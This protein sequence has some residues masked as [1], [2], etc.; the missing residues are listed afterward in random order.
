MAAH[1]L[2]T[3]DIRVVPVER[4]GDVTYHGPGQLVAYPIM[5]LPHAKAVRPFV[6]AL[7]RAVV[8]VA[9]SY[10]VA[11][12]P[13]PERGRTGVWVDGRKLAAIGIK[14]V[15]RVTMHGLAL[16]VDPDLDDFAGIVPCGIADADVCSLASLGVTTT[17]PEARRRL[18][19]ALGRSFARPVQQAQR[20]DLG[21]F[22]VAAP[23]APISSPAARR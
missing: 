12:A 20:E 5:A 1:V 23:P 3:R 21:L 9:A 6:E 16:N 14:V 4:G 18:V 22:P 10:G 17:M 2:G 15:G 11:A 19:D 13:S 7:E 8:E